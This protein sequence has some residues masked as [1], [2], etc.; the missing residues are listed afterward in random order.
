[1]KKNLDKTKLRCTT[2]ILRNIFC[3]SLGFRTL[4][5]GSTVVGFRGLRN[6]SLQSIIE[7]D[8]YSA[9]LQVDWSSRSLSP[10][11]FT[12]LNFNYLWMGEKKLFNSQCPSRNYLGKIGKRKLFKHLSPRLP[13]GIK[14]NQRILDNCWFDVNQSIILMFYVVSLH[15]SYSNVFKRSHLRLFCNDIKMSK[16]VLYKSVLYGKL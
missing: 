4:Y 7:I 12:V 9:V 13:P 2:V 14:L 1:M 11:K 8:V 16:N 5:W 6:L 10:I 3:Q 15:V